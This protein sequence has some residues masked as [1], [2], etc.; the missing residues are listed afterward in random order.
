M[1]AA[2]MISGSMGL[3]V[4]GHQKGEHELG[5][6]IGHPVP[7]SV[8]NDPLYQIDMEMFQHAVGSSFGFWMDGRNLINADLTIVKDLTP[9]GFN[10]PVAPPKQAFELIF[11]GPLNP[12][13]PQGTYQL[14]GGNLPV[15]QLFVVPFV[16]NNDA[17]QYVAI[18]NRLYP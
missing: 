15:F 12:E 13:L 10:G 1:G 16:P 8:Q 2:A 18:I 11:N 4:F 3:S 5:S 7:K 17:L 9:T 14:Y 6:G